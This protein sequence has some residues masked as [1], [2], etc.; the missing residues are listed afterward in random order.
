MIQQYMYWKPDNLVELFETA[1][2]LFPCKR[3]FGTKRIRQEIPFM[4]DID[5]LYKE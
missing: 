5:G 2:E 1:G 3:R 4:K